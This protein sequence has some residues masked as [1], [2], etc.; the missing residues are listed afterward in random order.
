MFQIFDVC[1]PPYQENSSLLCYNISLLSHLQS[2]IERF[3]G[4]IQY[5]LP[6]KKA[7]DDQIGRGESSIVFIVYFGRKEYI[8]KKVCNITNIFGC[9]MFVL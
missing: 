8:L 2:D 9:V 3:S 6:K 1:A 5:P 7:E 4:S